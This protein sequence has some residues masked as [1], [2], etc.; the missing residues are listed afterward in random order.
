[1]NHK[2]DL[3]VVQ[4]LPSLESGGVERGVLEVGKHLSKVGIKSIVISGGGRLVKQLEKEGSLHIH[5]DVGKKSLAT[6][7][8]IFNLAKIL[9]KNKTDIVHARSRLPAWIV[10]FCIKLIPKTNRPRFIT[11]I[12]GPYSINFY[13]S[14]MTKGE[15]VFVVS[16]MIKN[17]ATKNY[18]IEKQRIVLN[19]RGVDQNEFPYKFKPT[20]V[21]SQKWHKQYPELRK[22]IILTLPAR[23]TSWKGQDDFIEMIALLIKKKY[24]VHGLIVGEKKQGK[25]AYYINLMNKVRGHAIE[26]NITFTGYRKDIREIMA[27]SFIVY[28]LSRAPEAFG[29]VTLEALKMGVKV[30]GY[31][32]GGVREQMRII[33][34]TGLTMPQN[35]TK[36]VNLTEAWINNPPIVKETKLFSL[37]SMLKKT[38]EV[39][40][41][42]VRSND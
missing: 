25:D 28:S 2:E 29:R 12:H 33:L 4:I 24:E 39:Y 31:N 17:Y 21:W 22:K 3:V 1:M 15:K 18:K 34:P 27:S 40:K 36:L 23:L 26:R 11:T 35:I 32:H 10:F 37:N 19:Y 42:L 20:K 6:F 8:L 14:I 30:I 38:V 7:F 5:L 9:I 41:E 13:S 16:N